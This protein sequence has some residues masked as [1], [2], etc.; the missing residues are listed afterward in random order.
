MATKITT[1]EALAKSALTDSLWVSSAKTWLDLHRLRLNA[2]RVRQLIVG[3]PT[4][5][6]ILTA[7]QKEN[8]KAGEMR[9]GT[10]MLSIDV[11]RLGE[12]PTDGPATISILKPTD[13]EL[14]LDG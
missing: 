6:G 12:A 2:T 14:R 3:A 7:E 13:S 10:Y 5:D 1:R 9:E 11:N 4:V 8:R